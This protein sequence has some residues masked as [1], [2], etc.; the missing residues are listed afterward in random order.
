MIKFP[1]QNSIFI[2]GSTPRP[3]AWSFSFM[4]SFN[5]NDN[6]SAKSTFDQLDFQWHYSQHILISNFHQWRYSVCDEK[7][8]SI[9]KTETRISFFQSQDRDGNENFFLSIS[10]SRRE[11]EFLS[12][13]LVLRD[14]NES[15]FFQSQASRRERESRLWQFSRIC[16]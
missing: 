6:Q 5:L 10:C 14:E 1:L 13:N 9:L 15:F 7:P 4:H 2:S 8:I 12:L 11:R 16:F 3:S